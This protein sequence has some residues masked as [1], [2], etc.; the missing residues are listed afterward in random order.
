MTRFTL[1]LLLALAPASALADTWLDV[2]LVDHNC[3][4]RVQADPDSHTTVCLLQCA[5]SGY[6]I[7]EN[8]N[9]LQLDAA[10]NE[11]AISVLKAPSKKD[12]VRVNVTGDRKG[13]V[14]QVR[15]L[16]IAS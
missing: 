10:G 12:H 11:K 5:K 8:G 7:F 6:G 15:T 13:D 14:V 9:W 3:E 16:E 2:S 1:A 4:A